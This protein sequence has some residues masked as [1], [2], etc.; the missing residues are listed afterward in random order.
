VPA[1]DA[2]TAA[3]SPAWSAAV[4]ATTGAVGVGVE[5]EAAEV[6]ADAVVAALAEGRAATEPAGAAQAVPSRQAANPG[7]SHRRRN[8]GGRAVVIA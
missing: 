6:D 2:L 5:V 7:V 4:A 3:R 1:L 8:R